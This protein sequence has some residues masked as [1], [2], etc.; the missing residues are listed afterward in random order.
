MLLTH[1]Y[2]VY[3]SQWSQALPGWNWR[4]RVLSASSRR[5]GNRSLRRRNVLKAILSTLEGLPPYDHPPH[6]PAS[7]RPLIK[8]HII[9]PPQHPSVSGHFSCCESFQDPF[10]RTLGAFGSKHGAFR[11]PRWH[12][13]EESS[14]HCRRG[15]RWR[16]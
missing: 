15:K 3:S 9:L 14:C 13:G 6:S 10:P 11:L 7:F 8:G 12:S 2:P 1:C 5:G 16:V 4:L